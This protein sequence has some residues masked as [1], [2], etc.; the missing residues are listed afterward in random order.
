M[1]DKNPRSEAK[2]I[3][4]EAEKPKFIGKKGSAV[5]QQEFFFSC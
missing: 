3:T 4:L 1:Y 2:K 5:Y